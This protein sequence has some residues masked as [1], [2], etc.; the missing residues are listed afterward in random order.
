MNSKNIGKASVHFTHTDYLFLPQYQYTIE[1][2][3]PSKESANSAMAK[4]N[5]AWF[6]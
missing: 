2:G 6:K 5:T 4:D 3:V 1:K